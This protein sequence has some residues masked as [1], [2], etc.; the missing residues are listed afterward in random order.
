MAQPAPVEP[1]NLAGHTR[2]NVA[3]AFSE[4]LATESKDLS[5][6]FLKEKS[7][8]KARNPSICIPEML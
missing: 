8:F 5:G 6:F 2:Y 3:I 7:P 4:L 1:A